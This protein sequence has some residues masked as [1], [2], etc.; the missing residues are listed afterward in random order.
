MFTHPIGPHENESMLPDDVFR[1]RLEQ[2]LVDLETWAEETRGAADIAITA[3]DR[4][5]R[6]V[7][8]PFFP[9]ACPFELLIK[10]SQTFDLGLDREAYENKPI[11]RFDLF[12]ILVKAIVAGQVER[13]ETRNALTGILTNVA[14]RVELAPGWDWIGSRTVQKRFIRPLEADEEQSI[15]RFLSYNR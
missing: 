7:V 12:L 13:I 15:H 3:S 4:Y 2:T 10:A 5:W 9:G 1:E 11:Q 14:M 8:K 6:M